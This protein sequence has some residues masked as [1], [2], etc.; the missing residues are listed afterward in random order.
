MP[1]SLYCYPET[2]KGEGPILETLKKIAVDDYFNAVEITW[3][4]DRELRKKAKRTLNEAWL[5]M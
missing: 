2:I 4:K 1:A 5:R 3:I